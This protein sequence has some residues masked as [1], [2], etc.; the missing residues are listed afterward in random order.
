MN[1]YFARSLRG[2]RKD[3]DVDTHLEIKRAIKEAGHHP[4]FD[5]PVYV[6]RVGLTDEQYIYRRDID[7]IDQCHAMIAE[8]SNVSHGVGYEI[9][10]AKHVRRIPILLLAERGTLVSAMLSGDLPVWGYDT[11]GALRLH[12]ELFIRELVA[13]N[14][15]RKEDGG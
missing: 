11:L 13:L 2:D 14:D 12:V 10:Y 1:I 8:V 5:L 15:A 6:K 3:N 4:Q 7:W 9:A